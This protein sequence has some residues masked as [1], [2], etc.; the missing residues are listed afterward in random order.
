MTQE[1]LLNELWSTTLSRLGGASAIDALARETKAFL[2]PRGIRSAC[3]LLRFVLAYSCGAM[4]LRSTCAWAASAGL[5]DISNVA[6]LG[7]LR[8]CS[9]WMERLVGVLLADGTVPSA[10]QKAFVS[11]RCV[12]LV[13]ATT[14]T[15][16][17]VKARTSG[18][19]WRIHAAFDLP[20]ERFSHFELTDEKGAEKLDTI[21][22]IPGEICIADRGYM[23]A[24]R[25]AAVLAAGADIIVRA[26]WKQVRWLD[27]TG[28]PLDMI[29]L[30]KKASKTGRIDRAIGIARSGGAPLSL[31]LVAFRKSPAAIAVAQVKTRREATK[32][33]LNV[34]GDTLKAAEWT[35]LVTSLDARE[36]SADAVGALYRARWRI[37]MAFKRMKSLIGLNSPPGADPEVA[38]TWVLAHLLLVLLLEPHTSQ[39]DVG[40]PEVSPR[41]WLVDLAA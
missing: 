37:E 1:L 21:P 31:R 16:A 38:K 20:S 32:E 41:R 30:L 2:R 12:R 29:A 36:F 7:R 33:G 39:A 10:A 3:D 28:K 27:E 9:S 4:G 5:A 34:N 14:V 6:L 17:G 18:Q 23:R 24:D 15:K 13:D 19:L 8:N 22:I 40:A 11:G 26:G 35:I 25:L